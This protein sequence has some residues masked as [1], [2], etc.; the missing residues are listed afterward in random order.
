MDCYF[1]NRHFLVSRITATHFP[2]DTLNLK[3]PCNMTATST[4]CKLHENRAWNAF[5]LLC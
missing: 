3:C 1:I 2:L 5:L 4:G